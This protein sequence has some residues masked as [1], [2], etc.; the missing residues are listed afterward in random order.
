MY[1]SWPHITSSLVIQKARAPG[2][3]RTHDLQISLWST[4]IM[5]LTR[6]LLRYRGRCVGWVFRNW[7]I[8]TGISVSAKL[9]SLGCE[10]VNWQPHWSTA[11]FTH[12]LKIKC[13]GP[14]ELSQIQRLV[15]TLL[16][17]VEQSGAV[18]A[19]WAHNP[20]VRRSKLRSANNF[21]VS[22]EKM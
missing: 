7:L 2:E 5:R 1:A 19:C 14:F 10:L 8:L 20:E 17:A 16:A 13:L 15:L 18:E 21:S 12:M 22:F 4:W 6:C 11:K 3:D 9:S